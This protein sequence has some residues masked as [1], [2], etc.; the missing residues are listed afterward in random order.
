MPT[1][2]D[3]LWSALDSQVPIALVP[4]RLETRFGT[5]PD[6]DAN[7]TAVEVPVLRVRIYPDDVSVV[8]TTPGVNAVERAAGADFWAA[9]N[10][11]ET[12]VEAAVNGAFD[13]RRR[14]AWELMVRRVG[15]PRAVFVADST[16]PGAPP[17]A[18]RLDVAPT[19]RLLPDAW[20]ITGYLGGQQL[21][22]EF[23]ARTGPD[24]QVG[25]SR[26][27]GGDAFD[28]TDPQL[29]HPDDGLRWVTD[30]EAAVAVGMAAVIDLATVAQITNQAPPPVVTAGLDALVVVGV[31]EPT[32]DRTVEAEADLLADL[33]TAHAAADR[34][35]LVAQG[36]ATNNLTDSPAGWSS[37][38]DLF[39]GYDRVVNPAAPP[40]VDS[41]VAALHGGAADGPIL[42]AALG[43]PAGL[44][45]NVDGA[46]GQEQ[47]L[48]RN[49]A[50]TLFPVTLGEAI[51]TL[52]R[53]ITTLSASAAQQASFLDRLDTALPFAR[54]HVGAFVRGRGPLPAV[55]IG[56]Q[57]YGVLPIVAPSTWAPTAAEPP[58][59]GELSQIL[60]VLRTFW[61]QAASKVAT[62]RSGADPTTLLPRIL[63]LGPVP[64]PGGYRVRTVNGWLGA[65]MVLMSAPPPM[66]A[67][68][69]SEIA[70][71]IATEGTLS[72]QV[73]LA[74][75][76]RLLALTLGDLVDGTQLAALQLGGVKPMRVP[77]AA[78]NPSRLGWESPATYL[79]RLATGLVNFR[80]ALIVADNRPSDLLF[81]LAE[82]ALALA[83]ELDVF[84]LLGVLAP[85]KLNTALSVSPE[86]TESGLSIAQSFTTVMTAAASQLAEVHLDLPAASL[87]ALIADP[88]RRALVIDALQLPKTHLN[89]FAGTRAAVA[90]LAGAGL[91]DAGYT[92]LTSETLACAST[93]LDAWYTSLATQRLASLRDQRP[94]GV[95]LG[96]WG[97]L[98]DV[99]PHPATPVPAVPP[100]W[101][102]SPGGQLTTTPLVGPPRQV[103]FVHAPSLA[104]A[105]TAGVL[106]AGE[107]AHL[108]DSTSLAA[109]DLTSARVRAARDIIVAMSNGQP[110]GALLGYQ[111]ERALG[112]AG[113]HL[114][115]SR[116]RAAY[117]QRRVTGA[118]GAPV[119]PG[120]DSVVPA[121]VVDGLEVWQGGQAAGVAAPSQPDVFA[122]I[123]ADLART[124]DAV[125]DLVVAEG[126][127]HITS[128]RPDSAGAAFT[129]VA[130][131]TQLPDLTVIREPRS[132]ITLT[133]RA[134]LVLDQGG[135]A[136][137]NRSGPRALLAPETELWVESV[138]GAATDHQ[139]RVG[140]ATVGLDALNVSALDVL[141]ESSSVAS[142]VSLLQERLSA[143]AP[144]GGAA[145]GPAYDQLVALAQA[146]AELL[147][148]AR[149]ALAADL[150]APPQAA[151][152]DAGTV[153]AVPP[154]TA[155]DLQPLVDR[156][157]TQLDKLQAAIQAVVAASA[158]LDAV[159]PVDANLLTP[160]AVAG[161]PGSI[162]TGATVPLTDL[163]GAASAAAA[164]L[165]DVDT[166]I[167]NG[168]PTP[169]ADPAR[170][171]R[172]V[173]VASTSGGLDTLVA[174][175]RRIG[176]QPVVPTLTVSSGLAAALVAG[177]DSVAVERWLA[178][179]GRVRRGMAGLDDLRL[180]AEAA[181]NPAPTLR[182]YQFPLVAAEGWLGDPL[183]AAP[184]GNT[185]RQWARPD[186]PRVHLVATGNVAG[187]AVN[188]LIVDEVAEVLPAP[189]VSTGLA[190]HYDAP[191][192]RPPQTVLLAV[193]PRPNSH[194]SWQL[195]DETV[196]E[197]LALTQLRGVDLDDLAASGI[198]E[199]LPLT[200][201]R[202]GLADTGPLSELTAGHDWTSLSI[203]ANRVHL[204][205]L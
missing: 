127:H 63:G 196:R 131:G 152:P 137:W 18:D 149:P 180:F 92:R 132:G 84:Q 148:G 87:P 153:L 189:T 200:Y 17:V 15:Q 136:G 3:G 160:F 99:R 120:T 14:A 12:P 1:P 37:T 191:N 105:R 187:P 175:T 77:V 51:G 66:V 198:D 114:E 163:V 90:V 98:V 155:A 91:D 39:A 172:L 42:E 157:S 46:G 156:I 167:T 110:L 164:V 177:Q 107:L 20:V 22:A 58:Q 13:H 185:L 79:H 35:A 101:P 158:G 102:G 81:L 183:P 182:A 93:R 8:A 117:P 41:G 202:D 134:A 135:T 49:M 112:D 168:S 201:V 106:R 139:L 181:G 9:Q 146:T 113:M 82:H 171:A 11:P 26:Q 76:R 56:R 44:T 53:P 4:V 169:P 70:R 144:D 23:V 65:T 5:R 122:A 96:A 179:M 162:R 147:A 60:G 62:L 31:R 121:E 52:A 151:T 192:A 27:T 97:L 174:I 138:L 129:A 25:P 161:L 166:L 165:R 103:G 195:L 109:I 7:S 190:I 64:H 88:A 124:V 72:A 140:E 108:G 24:P 197:A 133:H 16:R 74:A 184:G 199:Y 55:R 178:R 194:W 57:P 143:A 86:V 21:F 80:L 19:A 50:L 32:G 123:I 67:T 154:P 85:Q 33:L 47:W 94:T 95:Q 203:P 75:F 130:D 204:G 45:A 71:E 38:A 126:V 141:A 2:P 111:L 100:D 69:G 193:H 89:G 116:L 43:L 78:T 61:T 59:L 170:T 54:E 30:F 6:V 40:A 176:G 145:I 29:V 159:A 28:P 83:G 104:Q 48:A 36:T 150:T 118:A 188:A 10:D 125:A 173:A 119:E 34:F 115:I 142:G 205:V 68:R 128:G 186:S 73:R